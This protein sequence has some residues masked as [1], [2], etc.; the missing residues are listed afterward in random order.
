[1]VLAVLAT[2]VLHEFLPLDFQVIPHSLI[3]YPLFL[4]GFLGV[5]IVGDPGRIDRERRWLRVTTTLM[6]GFITVTTA[7]SG[8]GRS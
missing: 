6:I 4:L 5:L 1:M 3:V 8:D 2:G 7:P